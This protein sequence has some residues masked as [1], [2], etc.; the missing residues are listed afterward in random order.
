MIAGWL[1]RI[2]EMPDWVLWPFLVVLVLVIAAATR[3]VL[4]GGSDQT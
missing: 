2:E 4:G 1:I 3:W